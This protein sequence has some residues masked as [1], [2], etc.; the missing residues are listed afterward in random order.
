MQQ[1]YSLNFFLQIASIAI[2][3]QIEGCPV[4]FIWRF[5]S[6]MLESVHQVAPY[7]GRQVKMPART[8]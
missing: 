8:E 6:R 7:K 2:L 5:S 3:C 1:S 4:T